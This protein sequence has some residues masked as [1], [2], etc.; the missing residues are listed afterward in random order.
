VEAA[1]VAFH[2]LIA[3]RAMCHKM[4]PR[5]VQL[6]LFG[7]QHHP[8][9]QSRL[10]HHITLQYHVLPFSAVQRGRPLEHD[11]LL[12]QPHAVREQRVPLHHHVGQQYHRRVILSNIALAANASGPVRPILGSDFERPGIGHAL[13][14]FA[15]S[16]VGGVR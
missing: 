7:L 14:G 16:H 13:L 1:A 2:N 9:Q 6:Q 15:W 12:S 8:I 11:A 5:L 3:L 4:I 10:A